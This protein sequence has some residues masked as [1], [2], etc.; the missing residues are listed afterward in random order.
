MRLAGEMVVHEGAAYLRLAPE[1]ATAAASAPRGAAAAPGGPDLDA[2]KPPTHADIMRNV[3]SEA[4]VLHNTRRGLTLDEHRSN[5]TTVQRGLGLPVGVLKRGWSKEAKHRLFELLRKAKRTRNKVPALMDA[6]P[7]K[8]ADALPDDPIE[9]CGPAHEKNEKKDDP[10][11]DCGAPEEKVEE[12][13]QNKPDSTSSSSSSDSESSAAKVSLSD[14]ERV[15]TALDE[16]VA[17]NN[18]YRQDIYYQDII[19]KELEEELRVAKRKLAEYES[20]EDTD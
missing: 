13:E 20:E 12:E 6:E 8:A 18:E 1:A 9:D 17:E 11:E 16:A 2:T 10:I 4:I 7:A 19:I 3:N 5:I 15:S 14:F